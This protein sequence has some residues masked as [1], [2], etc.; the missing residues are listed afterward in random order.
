MNEI[1]IVPVMS[2]YEKDGFVVSTSS[3]HSTGY[4]AWDAFTDSAIDAYDAWLSVSGSTY[5]QYL[6]VKFPREKYI[7]RYIIC[8]RNHTTPTYP[9]KWDLEYSNDGVLWFVADSRIESTWS[10]GTTKEYLLSNIIKAKY[11]RLKIYS[12]AYSSYVGIG[13]IKLFGYEGDGAVLESNN[14]FYKIDSN[15]NPIPI[16]GISTIEECYYHSFE[17]SLLPL[18][19]NL[20]QFSNINLYLLTPDNSISSNKAALE[21][22]ESI[23]NNDV[24]LSINSYV[25]S[26]EAPTEDYDIRLYSNIE[27]LKTLDTLEID[28]YVNNNELPTEDYDLRVDSNTET[29][30]NIDTQ[31][32]MQVTSYE[33]QVADV[34]AN[35]DVYGEVKS[36]LRYAISIDDGVSWKIYDGSIWSDVEYSNIYLNGMSMDFINALTYVDYQKLIDKEIY[37]NKV[38]IASCFYN[39]NSN[40]KVNLNNI[41]VSFMDNNKPEIILPNVTPDELTNGYVTLTAKLKDYEGDN[42]HYRVMIQKSS[43]G[44]NYNLYPPMTS[45]ESNGFKASASSIY[46]ASY[47]AWKAFNGLSESYTADCWLS[48]S[49]S[50]YPQWLQLESPTSRY[51]DKYSITSRNHT[52]NGFP[53]SWDLEVSDDGINYITVEHREETTW[54]PNQTKEYVLPKITKAKFFRL[55]IY[56]RG[57]ATYSGIAK[58][59]LNDIGSF[60]TVDNWF[61]TNKPESNIVKAYDYTYFEPGINRMI[62]EIKDS[63]NINNFYFANITVPNSSPDIVITNDDYR[64][65]ADIS[66]PENNDISVQIEING[67]IVLPFTEFLSS[68]RLF[69]YEWNSSDI[70]IGEMNK[71]TV[72]VKDI[73]GAE[74]SQ[75]FYFLGSYKN[76]LFYNDKNQLYSTGNGETLIDIDLGRLVDGTPSEINKVI[77]ENNTGYA[78]ENVLINSVYSEEIPADLKLYLS[79][80][81]DPFIPQSIINLSSSMGIK[82]RKDIYFK[83]I[84]NDSR[85]VS[86]GTIRMSASGKII[87]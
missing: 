82:E 5:P 28:S 4:P 40:L 14:T 59:E 34:K 43:Y 58:F 81:E 18:V 65:N 31:V 9:T 72:R 35:V 21:Y 32:P 26:N 63:R 29:P 79:E 7:T 2:G 23:I 42:I 74:R 53:T 17:L 41:E 25:N 44:K 22:F 62:L 45:N 51:I 19:K 56:G 54:N 86:P 49:G 16:E 78:L 11:I 60:D 85:G 15:F 10:Q 13:Y 38:L 77:L 3:E 57:N 48:V 12:S 30:I 46:N 61:D 67:N 6:Q 33:S 76:L 66:D 37:L 87:K 83:I 24:N 8:S 36:Y 64:M 39:K 71:G 73:W 69:K 50:T 55:M 70:L 47:D 68:P 80:S 27:S 1:N 84:N 52:S 20:D 75:N